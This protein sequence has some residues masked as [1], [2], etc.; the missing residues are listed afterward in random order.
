M[1]TDLKELDKQPTQNISK[2]ATNNL[3]A[4]RSDVL[5]FVILFDEIMYVTFHLS[6]AMFSVS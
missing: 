3:G 2:K 5:V 4:F 1:M 6:V